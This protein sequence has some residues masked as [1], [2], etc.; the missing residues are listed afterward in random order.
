MRSSYQA[1]PWAADITPLARSLS[2]AVHRPE[3]LGSPNAFF[4]KAPFLPTRP[5]GLPLMGASSRTLVL[6][7]ESVGSDPSLSY[8]PLAL[9]NDPNLVES[10][11]ITR[12]ICRCKFAGMNGPHMGQS[13]S[14]PSS[15]GSGSAEYGAGDGAGEPSEGMSLG[16]IAL[17][18]AGGVAALFL[19]GVL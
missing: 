3:R 8:D 13:C 10:V 18:G 15:G 5:V 4:S 7:N 16:T 12:P 9:E 17:V 1:S 6:V 11:D 19:L 2:F 14:L